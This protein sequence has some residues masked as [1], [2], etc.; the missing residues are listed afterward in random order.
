MTPEQQYLFLAGATTL[1]YKPLIEGLRVVCFYCSGSGK[2]PT[3]VGFTETP[4]ERCRDRGWTPKQ[5][6]E[7]VVALLEWLREHQF[8]FYPNYE[9][10]V[11]DVVVR[12]AIRLVRLMAAHGECKLEVQ[13]A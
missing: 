13:D 1:D 11:G 12:T 4:H 8:T 9:G 6:P 3:E 2:L 7:A 5:G 10:T